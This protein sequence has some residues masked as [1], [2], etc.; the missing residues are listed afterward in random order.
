[1]WAGWR[2]GGPDR[3]PHFAFGWQTRVPNHYYFY[4]RDRQWGRAF[5]KACC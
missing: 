5:I 3:H 2:Q 4:L 1:V